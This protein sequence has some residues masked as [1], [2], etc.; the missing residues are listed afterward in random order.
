[1]SSVENRIASKLYVLAGYRAMAS[2]SYGYQ[3]GGYGGG[4][5]KY[6]GG[7]SGDGS[8]FWL[9]HRRLRQN[10][11]RETGHNL[12]A[13]GIVDRHTE[14]V[15]DIGLRRKSAPKAGILKIS[16]EQAD[17]WGK[18]FDE[19]FDLWANDKKSNRAEQVNFYQSQSLYAGAQKRDNDQFIRFYYSSRPDLQNPL[20]F[21]FIDP[22]QIVGDSYSTSWAWFNVKDGIDK[23]AAGRE[24]G[25]N[26]RVRKKD[27]NTVRFENVRIPARGRSGRIMMIH[28]F[29]PDYPGQTRGYSQLAHALQEFQN[30]TDFKIS[31][32]KKAIN[33]SAFFMYTKPSADNPA[34]NPI[35]DMENMAAGPAARAFGSHPVPLSDAK[36][37]T[38]ESLTPL[39]HYDFPETYTSKPGS[40]AV[41]GLN[42]GEDLQP[43]VNTAPVQQYDKFVDSFS[44]YL[45]ASCGVP[46]EMVLMRFGNNFSASR[47]TLILFWR[48][49]R[50]GQNEMSID[51][52][53]PVVSVW[54]SEEIAAGRLSAP[55]WSDPIL[56]AAW[57]WGT[58]HGPSIPNIDP[59]KKAKSDQLNA[60]MAVKTL[61]QITMEESGADGTANRAQIT[62]EFEQLPESPF[63]KTGNTTG[64]AA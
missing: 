60:E 57:L 48:I 62:R 58:W 25:Y 34:S 16:Q 46:I 1:M 43:F 39:S 4:G 59:V 10:A 5:S 14:T 23:D 11:R 24:T 33:Q 17:A 31:H 50:I 13:K 42:R 32:I 64:N 52:L 9:D 63:R 45:A 8:G 12:L 55:G 56:R 61:D 30:L 20:Q 28:G 41:F 37:V 18:E 44:A 35:E 2:A 47:A 3:F 26:V 40:M 36:H 51:Y 54:A 53:D 38:D 19:R 49:A 15:A 27:G 21:E 22:E 29:K 6:P 7:L